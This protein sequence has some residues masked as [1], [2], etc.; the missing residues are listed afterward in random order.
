MNDMTPPAGRGAPIEFS[1]LDPAFIADPYP[2]YRQLREA[3]P[4]FK[5][6]QGF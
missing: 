6:Q 3:A 1:P 4:V 5:A 2:F